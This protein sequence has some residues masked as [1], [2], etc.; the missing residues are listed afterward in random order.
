[1]VFVPFEG[2]PET[3]AFS[4]PPMTALPVS[5]TETVFVPLP[6]WPTFSVYPLML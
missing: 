4:D 6:I 2:S 3:F 5:E 1:M